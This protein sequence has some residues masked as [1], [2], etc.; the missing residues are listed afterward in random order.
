MV[1]L[2]DTL[3]SK[4]GEGNL[5]AVRVRSQVPSYKNETRFLPVFFAI[6]KALSTLRKMLSSS[7]LVSYSATPK[8]I[9][10]VISK[11]NFIT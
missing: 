1:K 9:V 2:V 8:L 10:H 4:S 6:Y 11:P 5:V 3:D 7:S